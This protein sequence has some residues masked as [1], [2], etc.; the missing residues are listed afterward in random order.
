MTTPGP[1]I[2][3]ITGQLDTIRDAGLWRS[4]RDVDSFGPH[5]TLPATGQTVVSFAS[6]DY[7][8]LSAHPKVIAAAHDALDRWGAGSGASRLVTG[9]R[10]VHRDLEDALAVWKQT[11]RAVL[12]PTGFAANLGVLATLGAA[13]VHIVSDELNHASIIDGTRLARGPVTVARHRDL[14]H[15]EELVAG[16]DGAAMVVADTVFSMDGDVLDVAAVAD[17]CRRHGALLVL[18]EAHAV[19]G[20]DPDPSVFDG[21]EVVRVGTLSKALGSLG[22][23][24]ACSGPVADLLVNAARS[25]IFTTALSPAD[26]AAA[27]AALTIVCGPEGD[28]RRATL[29]RHVERIRPGHPTP[30]VPVVLGSEQRA[31]DA[32]ATLLEAGLLVPAIRPPTV[33]AGTSRL[34]VT[35]SAAHTDRDVD[36]L[37][38]AL[39]ALEA[40]P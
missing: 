15:L 24:V 27:L 32:A 28:D 19:L 29:R 25:S 34:R 39:D 4:Y 14:A 33:P 1:W 22:G 36:R 2:R 31:L 8:G 20:P 37:A 13:D 26:A 6:N 9:A 10:P 7:L 16:Q 35:L 30:I 3:R 23:F 11:E 38:E 40:H 12:F 21:V 5:G 18:D 17:I